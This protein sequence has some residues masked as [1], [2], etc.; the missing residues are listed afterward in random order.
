MAMTP[1]PK[2]DGQFC[3]SCRFAGTHTHSPDSHERIRVKCHR[4]PPQRLGRDPELYTP[5]SKLPV[6]QADTGWPVLMWDD[7]CGEWLR[8]KS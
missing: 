6:Q 8:R 1:N 5:R 2:P 3:G 7:W 4:Y